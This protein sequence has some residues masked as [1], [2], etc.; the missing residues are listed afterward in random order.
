MSFSS[1]E[2]NCIHPVNQVIQYEY[3]NRELFET[4]VFSLKTSDFDSTTTEKRGFVVDEK[5]VTVSFGISRS[6]NT[7]IQEPPVLIRS[8]MNFE[9]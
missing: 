2:I 8:T 3:N 7:E 1:P 6:I 9:F 4:G 5:T